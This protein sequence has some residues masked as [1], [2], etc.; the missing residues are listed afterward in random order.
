MKLFDDKPPIGKIVLYD[1]EEEY[2]K[3]KYDDGD[4]EELD[5]SELR[6]PEWRPLS[7]EQV[8]WVDKKHKKIIIGAANRWV[9]ILY[10]MAEPNILHTQT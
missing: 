10:M 7:R 5:F 3:I 8:L 4:E 9:L 6:V 1:V 2:Y